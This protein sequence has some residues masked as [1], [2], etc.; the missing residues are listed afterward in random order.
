MQIM[1]KKKTKPNLWVENHHC[2]L[3]KYLIADTEFCLLSC[4]PPA[5]LTSS[6]SYLPRQQNLSKSY[7]AV[8]KERFSGNTSDNQE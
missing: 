8:V 1:Q 2:E 5:G 4:P 6:S 7:W 3:R